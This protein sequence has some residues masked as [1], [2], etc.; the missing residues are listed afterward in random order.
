MGLALTVQ[1][2]LASAQVTAGSFQIGAP[3][4]YNL[5]YTSSEIVTGDFNGDGFGDV[6]IYNRSQGTSPYLLVVRLNDGSGGFRTP[7]GQA[8]LAPTVPLFNR[9]VDL[10][11]ALGED[12]IVGPFTSST[13]DAVAIGKSLGGPN[14]PFNNFPVYRSNIQ[15]DEQ[16]DY[17]L[18]IGDVDTD[19]DNDI[20]MTG[21]GSV[22]MFLNTGTGQLVAD[23]LRFT[24][25]SFPPREFAPFLIPQAAPIKSRLVYIEAVAR[26]PGP[27]V[28]FSLNVATY[29]AERGWEKEESL[30]SDT[31]IQLDQAT[32]GDLDGDGTQDLIVPIFS[33]F[34]AYT[35]AADGSFSSSGRRTLSGFLPGYERLGDIDGDGDDDFFLPGT[36]SLLINE[37]LDS[38][39]RRVEIE[40][41]DAGA[42]VKLHGAAQLGGDDRLDLL[43]TELDGM[44]FRIIPIVQVDGPDLPGSQFVV[45]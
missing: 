31:S 8:P 29:T 43:A 6:I 33:G 18:L 20:L 3:S 23:N 21:T 37:G 17:L 25:E 30:T 45:Y 5:S 7:D 11:G 15:L 32:H 2:S 10:D 14:Q 1:S 22:T 38:S 42:T 36:A 13:K 39:F 9:G 12:L 34:R 44:T 35:A 40:P 26:V 24:I 41:T 19:G 28:E 27:G 16:R 4:D